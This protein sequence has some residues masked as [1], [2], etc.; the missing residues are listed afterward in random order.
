M[1]ALQPP[2]TIEY[3]AWLKKLV[4]IL[5]LVGLFFRVSHLDQKV[6]WMDEGFT[7][8]AISGHTL[9]DVRENV[10]SHENVTSVA[11]LKKYQQITQGTGVVDT[12]NY[13]VNSDPQHPPLYY[14]LT[15][16]WAQM[17]GDTPGQL[18]ALSAV[19]SLL[20]FPCAYWL[21]I[22][23]YSSVPTA[24][25]SVGLMAISPLEIIFSQE[26]RQYGLWMVIILLNSATLL[27]AVRKNNISNW[28]LYTSI[29]TIGVYTHLFHV[30][31]IA[32]Q[33]VYVLAIQKTVGSKVV[34]NYGLSTAA[35]LLC[36]AP[37]IIIFIKH[38]GTA[39]DVNALW[40][41]SIVNSP[42]SYI[43]LFLLRTSRIFFDI[44]LASDSWFVEKIG[45]NSPML[46]NLILAGLTLAAFAYTLYFW[47][48]INSSKAGLF[49]LTLGI[50]PWLCLFISDLCF[51]GS[52]SLHSRY[53]LPLYIALQVSTAHIVNC[54]FLQKHLQKTRQ[55]VGLSIAVLALLTASI[56]S[57]ISFFQAESW[58]VS[59]RGSYFVEMAQAINQAAAPLIVSE[60][61]NIS[62]GVSLAISHRLSASTALLPVPSDRPSSNI[63]TVL[64]SGYENIFFINRDSYILEGLKQNSAYEVELIKPD[65]GFWKVREK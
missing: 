3:L 58:W 8:L 45:V 5:L 42:T 14:V 30:L 60:S 35:T 31:L 41:E 21:C 17:V 4:M 13:L 19:I 40:A 59:I 18:R 54:Q 63:P 64:P 12:V 38:I 37:W 15:R 1:N 29:A 10:F 26:A 28:L 39:L 2:S 46:L 49:I 22:E 65:I 52:L 16:I 56:V 44:N 47:L 9:A 34:R 33:G 20:I 62:L 32:G 25:I 55:K 61:D 7:S 50:F 36:F 6:Y 48:Y 27:R 57:D 23:L 24:W 51:G 11:A 43:F 53:H